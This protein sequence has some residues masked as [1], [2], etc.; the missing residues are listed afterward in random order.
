LFG[1]RNLARGKHVTSSS[2]CSSQPPAPAGQDRLS[3]L[4]DRVT[5]EGALAAIAWGH[6]TFAVCTATEVHPWITI[7]LGAEHSVSSVVVHPRA[8]CCWGRDDTPL[9]IQLSLEDGSFTTVATRRQPF[10]DDFPLS[11]SFATRRAR[12]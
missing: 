12:Y 11:A 6:G 1:R 10:T 5:V 9:D 7:D 4:V 3:R 8:D 2:L